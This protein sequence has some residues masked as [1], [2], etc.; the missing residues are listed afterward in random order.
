MLFAL[1]V[2]SNSGAV[3]PIILATPKTTAVIIPVFAVGKTIRIVTRARLEP[4]ATAVSLTYLGT[5]LK[6][7]SA[8]LA[9]VGN[10]K[11]A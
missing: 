2:V 6:T 11:I 4:R 9:T 8:V 5:S 3:S 1:E 10:I 7:S